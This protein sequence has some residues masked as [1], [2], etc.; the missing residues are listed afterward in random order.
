MPK[1]I[2]LE[3]ESLNTPV[4]KEEIEKVNQELSYKKMPSPDGLLG[5]SYQNFKDQIV[6]V[7]YE[8]SQSTEKGNFL[9]FFIKQV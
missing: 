2:P 8:L 9:I 6:P 7:F 5:E 3:I 4:S 1:W